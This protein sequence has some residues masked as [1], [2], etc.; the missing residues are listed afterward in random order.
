MEYELETF[1][2]ILTP[3]D[4]TTGGG[5]ASAIAGAMAAGLIAMV[6]RLSMQS[7]AGA[8]R[9]LL[10]QTAAQAQELSAQLLEGGRQDSEAFQAVSRAY[11]LPKQTEEQVSS[12]NLAVQAAWL[13]A[14]QVPLE[15]AG[16]CVQVLHLGSELLEHINPK[17]ASD[18]KCAFLLARAGAL[19][20]LENIAINLPAIKDLA[21]AGVLVQQAGALQ[22][23]LDGI[24]APPDSPPYF[25]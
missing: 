6:C 7:Q 17:T 12:R 10:D 5:S 23:K 18:L 1:K 14:T 21:A 24:Q 11:R 20:C 4:T 16:R 15:N 25:V 9:T 2:K 19:G 8:E 22:R 3:E 13:D